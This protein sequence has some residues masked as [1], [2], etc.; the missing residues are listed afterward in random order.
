VNFFRKSTNVALSALQSQ[1]EKS[2][3]VGMMKN[4]ASHLPI[5]LSSTRSTFKT[6]SGNFKG[7]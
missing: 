2:D 4:C 7:G 3:S 1:Q 5:T 6:G